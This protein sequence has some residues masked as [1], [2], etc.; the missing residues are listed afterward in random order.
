MNAPLSPESW[1]LHA[2]PG[3]EL[4]L[5]NHSLSG[6]ARKFGTPLHVINEARLMNGAR[7]FREAAEASYPGHLAVHYALK[8]NS[9]PAVVGAV[10][11]AGLGLEVMTPFELHL[12]TNIGCPAV[13]IVV[14]GPCKTAQFLDACIDARVRAIVVDSLD[15]LRHLAARSAA[16]G[17]GTDVLLRVNPDFT[18]HGV[19]S[20]TA[21]G[22]R[23]GCAFGLDLK[24]GEVGSALSVCARSDGI[25]FMGFHMHIGTGIR[26]P[27][28]YA[29]ALSCLGALKAA[30]KE[31]GLRI[32]L[33][34]AG[35]GFG[36]P[37]T[38]ELG[39][40]EFL[41]YQA[42][43]SFPRARAH[44][45]CG[46]PAAFARAIG[47][48]VGEV[49][50]RDELP[51]LLLEPGRCIAS[52]AQVLLLTVH[53]VKERKGAGRWL[54]AD[55]GLSTVTLPTFYEYHEVFVCSD[56]FRPRRSRATIVGPACFAGDVIYRNKPMPQVVPGEVIAIMDSGAYFTAMESSF[57]FPR[58]AIAAVNG[59]SCRLVRTRE[60]YEEM[61]GRDVLN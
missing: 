11:Q 29:R 12:A 53:Y 60:T 16:L 33:L 50:G 14:N 1:G 36:S 51:G 57:G 13:D 2:G 46:S 30:A 44:S 15:E 47:R 54:I 40:R 21:T 27:G 35:G 18:P 61:I 26:V 5:G 24:G 7:A 45:P 22:S 3:G 8:C 31:Y 41:L 48:A 25:R 17:L 43:G 28:E 9:V 34:D 59:A 37:T 58:P 55:G 23:R 4:S 49:F 32:R 19:N 42:L 6:L 39:T 38:R 52:G 10:L 56:P 20:G